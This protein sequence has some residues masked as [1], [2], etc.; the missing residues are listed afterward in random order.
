MLGCS[1]RTTDKRAPLGARN[2]FY[3][4]IYFI[5]HEPVYCRSPMPNFPGLSAI[6]YG[7]TISRNHRIERWSEVE[8]FIYIVI[9]RLEEQ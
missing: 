5:G 1:C 7:V 6:D 8:L 9:R 4:P 2:F 3:D